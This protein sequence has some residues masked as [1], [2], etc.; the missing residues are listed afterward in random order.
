MARAQ[1]GEEASGD[2]SKPNERMNVGCKKKKKK[3]NTTNAGA[4]CSRVAE[5]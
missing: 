1:R 5:K 2:N 3:E 4:L